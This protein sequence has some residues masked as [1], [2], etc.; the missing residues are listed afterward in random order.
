[1]DKKFTDFF[2]AWRFLNES[3]IFCP[4]VEDLIKSGSSKEWAEISREYN[5]FFKQSL[6][7][8]VQKVCPI[9]KRIMKN[10]KRNTHTEIWLECGEPYWSE[11]FNEIRTYHNLEYDCGGDTFE[12][13]IINLANIVYEKN[14]KKW[15]QKLKS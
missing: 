3:L 12:E 7:I 2:E 6:D 14:K 8:D 4:S 15:N 5:N 13:A 10:K 1:M 11:N 9:K